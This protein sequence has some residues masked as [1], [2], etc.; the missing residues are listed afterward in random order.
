MHHQEKILC[1]SAKAKVGSQL[2]GVRQNNGTIAI[3]PQALPVDGEF[4]ENA[5]L[6]DEAPE[7]RFRFASKCVESGCVQWTGKSCGIADEM[8]RHLEKV[9]PDPLVRPCAIR[10]HCRWY[11]QSGAA[12]CLMCK[13]VITQITEIEATEYYSDTINH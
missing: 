6:F 5:R 12:A 4:L 10:P 9:A 8:V 1:P 2:I 3:L 7:Q 11:K 13:Y